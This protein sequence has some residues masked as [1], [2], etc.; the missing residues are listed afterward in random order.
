[1][2][3]WDTVATDVGKAGAFMRTSGEWAGP[4]TNSMV[5]AVRG[6]IP[7]E[8]RP[9]RSQR[10][11]LSARVRAAGR[12]V[13]FIAK[14]SQGRKELGKFFSPQ[15]VISIDIEDPEI[16]ESLNDDTLQIIIEVSGLK[17]KKDDASGFVQAV[18]WQIEYLWMTVE[19][20]ANFQ[21]NP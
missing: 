18:P 7:E 13:V 16:L 20:V 10:I 14:T 4:F 6:E 15:Q 17:E 12:D 1:L 8:L 3:R 9:L 5:T 2:I 21:E 19:G 11:A